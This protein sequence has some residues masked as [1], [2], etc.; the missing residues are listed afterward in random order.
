MAPS[1]MDKQPCRFIVIED[2]RKMAE[3]SEAVKGSMGAFGSFVRMG[4]RSKVI[5]DLVFHGAPLLI[6]IAAEKDEWA[7]LD[8]A[9]AAQN[10]M[11]NGP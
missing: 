8:C 1:A 11:L 7:P 4:E 2:R 9:L 3:I 6:L 5:K 10:M